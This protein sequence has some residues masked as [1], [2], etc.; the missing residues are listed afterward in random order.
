MSSKAH[1]KKQAAKDVIDI[2]EEIS[3]LLVSGVFWMVQ[4]DA[5]RPEELP[6]EQTSALLMRVSH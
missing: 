3:L 2:I 1:E 5:N 6:V 4:C